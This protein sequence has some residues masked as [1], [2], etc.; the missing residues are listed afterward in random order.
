M[1]PFDPANFPEQGG[2][3][4]PRRGGGGAAAVIVAVLA[5][6]LLLTPISLVSCADLVRYLRGG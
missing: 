5:V 3:G 1:V 4:A 2:D 6:L